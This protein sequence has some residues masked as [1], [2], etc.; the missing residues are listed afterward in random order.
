MRICYRGFAADNHSWAVVSQNLSRS[1]IRLGHTV[2][3]YSTNG[4]KHFPHDLQKYLIGHSDL[5]GV[6]FGQVPKDDYDA[7]FSYTVLKNF[8]YYLQH[9]RQNRLGI[10]C[11]EFDA[12]K[13][14][15]PVGYA[16]M[17]NYC[18]KIL[19]PSQYN[20]RIFNEAG[21]PLNKMELVPH[22]VNVEEI[23]MAEA[24]KLKTNKKIKILMN[25]G[26]VHLRK[27]II[28]ALEMFGKAFNSKDDV[29][30]VIK[31]NNKKITQRFELSFP[32]LYSDFRKKFP[33]HAEVEIIDYFIPNIYSLYKACD[34]TFSPSHAEGF[35][36]VGLEG[37]SVGCIPVASRHGGFLEYLNPSNSFLISGELFTVSKD[38]LYYGSLVKNPNIFK[39]FQPSIEDGVRQ[40]MEAAKRVED[41][42]FRNNLREEAIN[43]FNWDKIVKDKILPLLK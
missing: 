42:E 43:N 4:N 24:F 13:H 15:L 26:Q 16:K 32:N 5:S 11:Y 29:C 39:A 2:D 28:N 22:G 21:I 17:H 25:I 40:L 23:E 9:S 36:M 18:D 41:H 38:F 3:I 20:T 1:L 12:G 7:C 10:W 35:G 33:N 8:P 27:N 14:S 6:R 34:I 19:S 30:L 31:V 37:M